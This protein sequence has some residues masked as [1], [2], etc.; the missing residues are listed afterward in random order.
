[1]NK[2]F[3]STLR[4]DRGFTLIELLVVI[5]IIAILAAILFPV[6]AKARDKARQATCTSNLKQ[7]GLALMQYAQDWDETL[8]WALL[9]WSTPEEKKATWSVAIASYIGLSTNKSNQRTVFLCPSDNT[10]GNP[11]MAANYIGKSSYAAN[12]GVM[13]RQVSSIIGG[14]VGG[15]RLAEITSP[16][17]TIMLVE[18]HT[19]NHTIGYQDSNSVYYSGANIVPDSTVKGVHNGGN[20]WA[21]CDGHISWMKYDK[22]LSPINMWVANQ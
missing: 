21:F 11:I 2:P 6:F 17:T 3:T 12:L 14:Q 10:W 22:S 1:M 15:R 9:G 7:I 13:D 8:P 20:N 4:R 5:A 18:V 19:D 16:P